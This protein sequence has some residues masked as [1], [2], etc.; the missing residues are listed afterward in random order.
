MVSRKILL[1]AGCSIVGVAGIGLLIRHAVSKRVASGGLLD[2][3]ARGSS[4]EMATDTPAAPKPPSVVPIVD[5]GLCVVDDEF[6]EWHLESREVCYDVCD[7]DFASEQYPYAVVQYVLERDASRPQIGFIVE[8][9]MMT[10][11]AS[12]YVERSIQQM[13]S[14]NVQSGE[15]LRCRLET[16]E[17]IDVVCCAFDEVKASSHNETTVVA[18]ADNTIRQ[19]ETTRRSIFNV[20]VVKEGLAV[21]IQMTCR[22]DSTEHHGVYLRVCSAA[23]AQ[24]HGPRNIISERLHNNLLQ[25]GLP[26]TRPDV[27]GCLVTLS[28]GRTQLLSSTYPSSEK[29]RELLEKISA[30]GRK[31]VVVAFVE[32]RTPASGSETVEIFIAQFESKSGFDRAMTLG[33]KHFDFDR[34]CSVAWR[35]DLL[36]A[37]VV[38]TAGSDGFASNHANLLAHELKQYNQ[39]RRVLQYCHRASNITY[40]VPFG[41]V[42][43]ST[44]TALQLAPPPHVPSSSSSRAAAAAAAAAF[45]VPPPKFLTHFFGPYH[46]QIFKLGMPSTVTSLRIAIE[47]CS[48]NFGE[49]QKLALRQYASLVSTRRPRID[50]WFWVDYQA[51]GPSGPTTEHVTMLEHQ[52]YF[53]HLVWT[54]PR[55]DRGPHDIADEV[56]RNLHLP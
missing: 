46:F 36:T 52:G 45:S 50:G 44:P 33:T 47:P 19:V 4:S 31:V 17:G 41:S 42:S 9:L 40:S 54:V 56:R 18:I 24:L 13:T 55:G 30:V 5:L 11:S 38:A 15:D 28:V 29:L 26:P 1:V 43:E 6:S 35:R 10:T 49:L 27:P 51:V 3:G 48:G 22:A 39:P 12:E 21:I 16:P 23:L 14:A 25:V 8:D 32:K 20:V 7:D 34:P 53:V 2:S 37:I